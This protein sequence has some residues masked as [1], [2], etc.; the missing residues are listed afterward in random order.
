MRFV[1]VAL[2][3]LGCTPGVSPSPTVTTNT[4]L[5]SFELHGANAFTKGGPTCEG[6]G[7]DDDI[8]VG[9]Q[10]TVK[11]EAGAIIATG[12]LGSGTSTTNVTVCTFH[13]TV[14][15]VPDVAFYSIEVSHR[16][17]LTYSAAEMAAK[18]WQVA[19]T[20]GD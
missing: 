10:I 14:A 2:L 19:F 4:L 12:A 7:G 16:G 1:I 18:N 5:G 9:A 11:D 17:E 20:L 8:A 3:L 6:T 13:F 15:D